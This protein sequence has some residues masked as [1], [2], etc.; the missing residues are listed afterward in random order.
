MA[1]ADSQSIV[2]QYAEPS[3]DSLISSTK[4]NLPL[5]ADN[6]VTAFQMWDTTIGG[7]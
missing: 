1:P 7:S 6:L 4:V 2:Q 5:S 3:F